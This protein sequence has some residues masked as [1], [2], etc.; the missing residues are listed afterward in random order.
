[1]LSRRLRPV[2]PGSAA[3]TGQLLDHDVGLLHRPVPELGPGRPARRV[4]VH[5]GQAEA[6]LYR[7]LH[8]P[9][10]L[11]LLERDPDRGPAQPT[12]H[13][14]RMVVVMAGREEVVAQRGLLTG[15][16]RG[17]GHG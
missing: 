5:G 15:P 10:A 9:D 17:F 4:D 8:P 12:G 16:G 2:K 7:T 11:R 13:A 1:P 3:E 14:H 6:P